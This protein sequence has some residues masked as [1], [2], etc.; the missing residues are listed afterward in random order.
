M[1]NYRLRKKDSVSFKTH[2][3]VTTKSRNTTNN[4]KTYWRKKENEY[5]KHFHLL[6]CFYLLLNLRVE[7]FEKGN[8]RNKFKLSVIT[9]GVNGF[10]L[11]QLKNRD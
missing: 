10:P 6:D 5:R 1:K 4:L 11:P 7:N 3:G 8:R 2:I 9:I